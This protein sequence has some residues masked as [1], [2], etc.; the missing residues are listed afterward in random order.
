MGSNFIIHSAPFRG[1][2]EQ[3]LRRFNSPIDLRGVNDV[4][5]VLGIFANP[6]LS[7]VGIE[8]REGG[9]VREGKISAVQCW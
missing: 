6:C 5:D 1:E 3:T 4:P 2:D 8:C 7:L 9:K